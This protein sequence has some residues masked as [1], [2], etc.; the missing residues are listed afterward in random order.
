M[1]LAVIPA[2][3]GSQ[4][5][6]YKNIRLFCGQPILAYSVT[7]AR[8]SGCF[9]KIIVSTDD[10]AI[11]DT[12]ITAGAE[13]PFTRPAELADEFSGTNAV[14]AHAIRWYHEQG[15]PV[16]YAC[17]LYATAPFLQAET[18]REGLKVLRNNNTDFVVTVTPFSFPVQRAVRRDKT[19]RLAPLWPEH[20]PSR[21]QDLSQSYHDA[22]QMYWGRAEAFLAERPLF[23]SDTIG[24]VVTNERTQDIDTEEDWRLAE[25]KFRLLQ[26]GAGDPEMK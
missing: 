2:R 22:G 11:A 5:I 13:V 4:R 15:Q 18:I 21:S 1:K 8:D 9:D 16:E 3:G 19:G 12:A 17:C 25:L 20:I 10:P 23:I 7:A 14:T 24:I 6:P 26:A